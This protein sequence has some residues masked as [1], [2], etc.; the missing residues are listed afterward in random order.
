MENPTLIN[1]NMPASDHE[2]QTMAARGFACKAMEQSRSQVVRDMETMR[3]NAKRISDHSGMNNL[4]NNLLEVAKRGTN[5]IKKHLSNERTQNMVLAVA[6]QMDTL[7]HQEVGRR[8]VDGSETVNSSSPQSI[9]RIITTAIQTEKDIA[10]DMGKT[11]AE[12]VSVMLMGMVDASVATWELFKIW[13]NLQDQFDEAM[14]RGLTMYDSLVQNSPWTTLEI[15]REYREE[16][17]KI[18]VEM[19]C[20]YASC[21]NGMGLKLFANSMLTTCVASAGTYIALTAAGVIVGCVAT[22]FKDEAARHL[23][24]LGRISGYVAVAAAVITLLIGG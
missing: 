13:W 8:F 2:M 14:G 1:R 4:F 16:L 20:D 12:F 10:V 21:Y 5:N 3:K 22:K 15:T 17:T 19:Q 6:Q 18:I 11:L 23:M 9:A 24:Q 7:L